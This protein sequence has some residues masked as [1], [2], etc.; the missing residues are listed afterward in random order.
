M[1]GAPKGCAGMQL[2]TGTHS[3]AGKLYT[4]LVC[5]VL[6]LFWDRVDGCITIRHIRHHADF[7][8]FMEAQVRSIVNRFNSAFTAKETYTSISSIRWLC[9]NI[10]MFL[11]GLLTGTRLQ[12]FRACILLKWW[13]NVSTSSSNLISHDPITIGSRLS[14]CYM[15]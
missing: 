12:L 7:I 4:W 2:C 14:I 13:I 6:V 5:S 3:A 1:A 9:H 8:L 15:F 11:M 10:I